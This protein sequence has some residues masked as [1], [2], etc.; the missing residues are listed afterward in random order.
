MV[1]FFCGYLF[2]LRQEIVLFVFST[3]EVSVSNH[4][5]SSGWAPGTSP[6]AITSVIVS[7]YGGGWD[8]SHPPVLV[9]SV[10]ETGIQGQG[11]RGRSVRQQCSENC[12]IAFPGM[13]QTTWDCI[14]KVCS[15]GL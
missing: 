14:N 12:A 3:E 9:R 10:L 6:P 15:E 7:P 13:T 5:M 2:F 8:R 4:R 1:P 11:A